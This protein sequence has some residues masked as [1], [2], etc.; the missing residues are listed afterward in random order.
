MDFRKYNSIENSYQTKFLLKVLSRHPE[1]Q[2]EQYIAREKIDGANIQLVFTPGQPMKVGKRTSFLNEGEAFFDIWNTL[3]KY[4]EE[5]EILQ[6]R[7]NLT[8]TTIRLY[9]E[10]YGNGIQKRVDYGNEKYIVFFDIEVAGEL[11]SQ[12]YFDEIMRELGLNDFIPPKVGFY[13]N[14]NSAL[15]F[16][17]NFD[18]HILGK[19]NNPAE[20]IVIQPYN[21]VV[22]LFDT[23]DR[24]ILKKKSDKFS[25]KEGVKEHKPRE[26]INPELLSILTNFRSYINTNR[27]LS[28]FS[29]HGEIQE[30]KEIGKYIKLI[31][32]DAKEDFLKDH[33]IP[34]L[35]EK[36]TKIVFNVGTDIALLLRS[37]L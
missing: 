12:K 34:E 31:L 4:K 28:V 9:G 5:L 16:D 17:V 21:K 19:D 7:T 18:S 25:E 23:P 15:N 37:Y 14:L 1:L 27:V 3:E 26:Q 35:D 32:D 20:G 36:S 13:N 10:I 11:Q 2:E 8:E 33:E 6:N 29:K 24:F 30:P 22:Y